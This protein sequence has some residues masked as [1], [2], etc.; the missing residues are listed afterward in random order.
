MLIHSNIYKK[1]YPI[2]GLDDIQSLS[3]RDRNKLTEY[4]RY[5][6]GYLRTYQIENARKHSKLKWTIKFKRSATDEDFEKRFADLA[7]EI[8]ARNALTD[9]DVYDINSVLYAHKYN[10]L[11]T[12]LFDLTPYREQHP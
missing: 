5:F 1:C 7:D 3:E 4:I 9:E 6:P 11:W 10:A 12:V 2:K 8:A